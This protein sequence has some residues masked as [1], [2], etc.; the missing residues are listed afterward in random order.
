MDTNHEPTINL[1]RRARDLKGIKKILI[2]S[3]VRYDIAVER[4]A[5]YQRTGDHY[6][7]G[8]LKIA[9]EHTEEGPLSKMMKPGMGSYD[10]FKE[11]FDT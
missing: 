5:L 8:Y 6:V 11:L 1:Y 7:G 10:R 3:G 9:P 4:S 2:A